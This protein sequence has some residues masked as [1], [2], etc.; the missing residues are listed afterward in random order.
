MAQGKAFD[1]A[2]R[3]EVQRLHEVEGLKASRIAIRLQLDERFADNCPSERTVQNWVRKLK[4]PD[5]SGPW[6]LGTAQNTDEARLVPRV[7]AAVAGR[8]TDRST[9][10]TQREAKLATRIASSVPEMRSW[11][12]WRVARAY[13]SHEAWG[14][15]TGDLD[16]LVGCA[17]EWCNPEI[18]DEQRELSRF[19]QFARHRQ[20]W[21]TRQHLF[22]LGAKEA[23]L[24]GIFTLEGLRRK[25]VQ[26]EEVLTGSLPRDSKDAV[27]AYMSGMAIAGHPVLEQITDS[28][29][30][31]EADW[32][33]ELYTRAFAEAI[34]AMA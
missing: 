2:V 22:V 27:R 11:D 14:M 18:G 15:N 33:I 9:G 29:K 1:K 17:G 13:M 10:L 19:A 3:S 31:V 16:F 21:P 5:D 34:E 4:V 23:G 6:S 25:L 24:L 32:L 26:I 12:V 7:W 30:R 20:L 28:G 8:R